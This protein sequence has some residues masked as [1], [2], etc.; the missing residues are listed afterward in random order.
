MNQAELWL[1][2]PQNAWLRRAVFQ[3]HL[4]SGI[5]LGVY[6]FLVSL[7]GSAI[8]FRNEFNDLLLARTHVKV[9]GKQLSRE[10]LTQAAQRTYPGYAVRSITPGRFPEEA[11]DVLL[12]KGWRHQDRLFD[13]YLGRDI[14][15]SVKVYY[16]MLHWAGELHGNLLFGPSGL[17]ANGVG[18]FLLA[19]MCVTGIVVWWPGIANWRRGMALRRGVGWKRLNWDLHSVVGFWTVSL[20]LMWGLTGAYFVFPD[21]FRAVIN[22][23]TPISP[24][25]NPSVSLPPMR[26]PIHSPRAAVVPAPRATFTY[27]PLRK[28]G[29]RRPLTT[30][31]KIL[32][33]FSAAHYGNF[34]GW[35]VK[36]LWVILGFAPPAL[37]VTGL[38][39]WWNRVLSPATR[40]FLRSPQPASIQ[41]DREQSRAALS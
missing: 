25:V 40:R 16:S 41:S 39:M 8:V 5:T 4:W 24:P 33:G 13:P 14:G 36:A 7:S 28:R 18:G 11:T 19:M 12:V 22:Y 15:P 29:P 3:V 27:T 1:R 9:S 30:G 37:F 26:P 31:Q 23:F 20:I 2:R 6:V 21:P 38:V 34:G 32:F 35:P 10:Q 17:V